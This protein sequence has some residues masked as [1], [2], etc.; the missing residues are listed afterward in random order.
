MP[1]M[2]RRELLPPRT[3]K[4]R[5]SRGNKVASR[6]RKS[7]PTLDEILAFERL[8]SDLSA[9]FAK[10]TADHVVVEIETALNQLIKFLGFGR[11]TF[12]EFSDEGDLSVLCSAAAEGLEPNLRG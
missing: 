9:R 1:A 4:E 10:V 12:G 3:K 5:F 2:M 8:L 6:R 11:G 7:D